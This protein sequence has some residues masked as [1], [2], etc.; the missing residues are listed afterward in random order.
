MSLDKIEIRRLP[1]VSPPI[2]EGGGRVATPAGELTQI[3]SGTPFLFLAYIEFL[4]DETKPRGNHVHKVKTET[5]YVIKGSLRA[6]YKDV[7]LGTRKEVYLE[8]GDLVT[9]P[10]NV[11]HVYY[12]LDYTQTVELADRPYDVGDTTPF[13]VD[14]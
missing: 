11:A 9:V 4:P 2:P 6:I 10:P 12:A 8:S 7:E 13:R 5:L 3:V 14:G 1:I